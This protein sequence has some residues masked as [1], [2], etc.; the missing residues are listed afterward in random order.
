M[1][2]D[3][4]QLKLRM[5][6]TVSM[7]DGLV[8]NDSALS[9]RARKE[10]TNLLPMIRATFVWLCFG[11]I[12]WHYPRYLLLTENDIIEKPPPYQLTA[13]GDVILD[14][15]L[16][17]KVSDQP[18]IPCTYDSIPNASPWRAVFSSQQI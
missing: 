7:G 15:T 2:E 6:R 11:L 8:P 10:D 4:R 16:N 5:Q 1:D 13:A 3:A 18:I 17:E 12:A 9:N 14:F